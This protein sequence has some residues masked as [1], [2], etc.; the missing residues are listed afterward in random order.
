VA[1]GI[2]HCCNSAAL[3][4]YPEMR[5]DMVR[6][7]IILYGLYPANNEFVTSK[8]KLSPVM[9]M[10]TVVTMVKP[11]AAGSTVSYGRRYT[12]P[13]DEVI[14]STAV[15]YAD[16]YHRLL[17]NRGRMIVHGQYAKVAGSVCMDQT[18]LEVTGIP[19]VK[20][21]DRVTVF[22]RDGDAFISADEVA[23]LAGTINYE[24]VC[25][26]SRRVP[27]CYYYQGENI[28]NFDYLRWKEK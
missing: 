16:G 4:C 10:R 15:G 7:G 28:H 25:A 6:P 21:G 5:L 14:A 1:P 19:G 8:I 2:R 23:A 27:R 24:V 3:L 13:E 11:L 26:M 12:A 22:G 20:E 17:T 9:E 18:M